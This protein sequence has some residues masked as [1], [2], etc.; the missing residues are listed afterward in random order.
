MDENP[1]KILF[2]D[3]IDTIRHEIDR[4]KHKWRLTET[5]LWM[6]WEDV[7][8]KIL[9]HIHKKWYQFDPK[10]AALH[11]WLNRIISHQ[12]INMIRNVYSSFQSPCIR[13]PHNKGGDRCEVFGIQY[14]PD[15]STFNKWF[16]SKR[17]KLE[18]EFAQSQDAQIPGDENNN[19]KRELVSKECSF[20]DFDTKIPEF[21]ALLKEKLKPI[22]WKAYNYLFIEHMSD[23]QCAKCLGY[24]TSGNKQSPGY[25]AVLKIKTAIYKAAKDVVLNMEF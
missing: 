8:M 21:N 24:N 22:E 5:I 23:I 16:S 10:K 11:H 4:R 14:S 18:I 9:E 2:E 3:H 19:L 1:A 17:Y 25:K 7:H 12:I 6:D 13:C 15:C 20:L